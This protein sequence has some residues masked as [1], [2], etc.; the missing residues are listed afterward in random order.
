M[1]TSASATVTFMMFPRKSKVPSVDVPD[2]DD[3]ALLLEKDVGWNRYIA[4]V[5]HGF[6]KT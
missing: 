6:V 4:S 1:L 3:P 5:G 2:M